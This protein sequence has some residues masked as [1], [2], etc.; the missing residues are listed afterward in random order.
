VGD[1]A[2]AGYGCEAGSREGLNV[3]A[4]CVSNT[5]NVRIRWFLVYLRAIS[6]VIGRRWTLN[7]V[8]RSVVRSEKKKKEIMVGWTEFERRS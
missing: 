5:G 6:C 1:T 4:G 7:W 8:W 2:K 3:N